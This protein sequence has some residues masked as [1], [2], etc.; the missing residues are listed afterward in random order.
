MAIRDEVTFTCDVCGGT[1]TANP[2]QESVALTA[3]FI[4]ENF[5]E[6][7][8]RWRNV[9]HRCGR[10]LLRTLTNFRQARRSIKMGDL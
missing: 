3:M 9:C 2:K 5:V 1:A 7:D 8:F 10:S 4:A 6:Q